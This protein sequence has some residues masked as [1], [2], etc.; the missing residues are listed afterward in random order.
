M[1]KSILKN[2]LVLCAIC[3]FSASYSQATTVMVKD[4]A[5][6]IDKRLKFGCGFGLNFVGG[7]NIFV[8]P[9]LIYDVSNKISLG[10]GLQASYA[11]IKDV[12]NTTTY[13]FNIITQYTP[14]PMLTT[15][16][17]LTELR[18]STKTENLVENITDKYWDTA[19]FV[20]AGLNVTSN[21]SIGAKVN[22]LYDSDKTVY[23]SAVIPF[24]NIT[25]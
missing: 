8:A 18:V 3:V 12:Q 19:L 25:F 23:T 20:G 15:L 14:T 2:A 21:I 11:G 24:V 4:S 1:K 5:D 16:L 13:G 10:G 22:L 17:E 6:V 7:T 9:N